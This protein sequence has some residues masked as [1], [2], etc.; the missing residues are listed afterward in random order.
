MT[1]GRLPSLRLADELFLAAH[2]HDAARMRPRLLPVVLSIGLSGALLAELML[3]N[4]IGQPEGY[5]LAANPRAVGGPHRT[6]RGPGSVADEILDQIAAHP[7]Q[8]VSGWLSNLRHTA[9][10]GV[11]DR[12]FAEGVLREVKT[13]RWWGGTGVEYQAVNLNQAL[14]PEARIFGV[15][16]SRGADISLSSALLAGLCDATGLRDKLPVWDLP[17]AEVRTRMSR[18]RDRLPAPLRG[19]LA[20]VETSVGAAMLSTGH[21]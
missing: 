20:D 6:V 13:R 2:D 10:E 9:T 4:R 16:N 7:G 1:S 11:V 19:L 15:A 17:A 18:L 3:E 5:V 21:H 8:P 14:G 12:L